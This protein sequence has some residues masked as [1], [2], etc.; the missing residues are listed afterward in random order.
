MTPSAALYLA[1]SR[2]VGPA[3]ADV[4][5]RPL[6]FRA[7]VGAVRTGCQRV[8]VPAQLRQR[9]LAQAVAASPSARAAV[10]WLEP[11]VAPPVGPLLLLPATAL[12]PSDGLQALLAAAPTA[13]L[14]ASRDSGVPAI[15]ARSTLVPALW[16]SIVAAR[17]LAD[18]LLR[19][20][21]DEPRLTV[22]EAGWCTRVT[23]SQGRAE[24]EAR[25]DAELLTPIDTPLDVLFHRRLSR[26]LSRLAVRWQMTP[27]QVTLLSLIVGLGAAWCF[28]QADLALALLGFALYAVAVVL[29]HVDGEIARVTLTESSFGAKL[30]VAVDTAIHALLVMAMGGAAQRVAGG[31]A[32][33]SGSA[34]ALGVIASALMTRAAPPAAGGIGALLNALSNRGGFYTMLVLFVTGLALLPSA[35]PAFMVAVAAGCHAFWL[36]RL[37][38]GLTQRRRPKTERKPK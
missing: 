22:V 35:L 17:P 26:P 32:A 7:V 16:A 6:A 33:L 4:A 3:L 9:P 1:D 23:S 15:A 13:V 14:A 25:L 37:A 31:G 19:A 38:Y 30:D 11:G 29:D 18:T 12:I 20:L 8:F 21:K 27:N 24:A 5:G 28:G 10:V 34:A 2:D 36:G